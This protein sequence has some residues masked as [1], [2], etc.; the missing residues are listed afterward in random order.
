MRVKGIN[1]A[2]FVKIEET[3]DGIAITLGDIGMNMMSV[4]ISKEDWKK[5]K[6][7]VYPI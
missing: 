1:D 5:I 3:R 4:V 2:Y 6:K 7:E